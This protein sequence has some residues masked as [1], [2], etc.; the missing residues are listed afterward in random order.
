MN[1]LQLETKS[2]LPRPP[3]PRWY[4]KREKKSSIPRKKNKRIEEKR[5]R[6]KTKKIKITFGKQRA[7]KR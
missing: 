7:R 5:M 2:E 6:G 4:S 3:P 1:N